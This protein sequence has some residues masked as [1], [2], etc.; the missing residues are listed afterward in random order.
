MK[1]TEKLNISLSQEE[2]ELIDGWRFE[3]RLPSRAAA[4]RELIGRS[5]HTRVADTDRIPDTK[6]I[7][8]GESP[9]M[10]QGLISFTI[11]DAKLADAPLIYVSSE[12]EHL[13][14]YSPSECIG[15]NCRFLQGPKT[16]KNAISKI[17]EAVENARACE[18]EMINYRKTGEP[19]EMRLK[20]DPLNVCGEEPGRFIV[21]TQI[22]LRDLSQG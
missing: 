18:V 12:F 22:F 11:A 19:F 7:G 1:R 13:S 17:R 14:G 6:E 16:R 4:V 15:R 9:F 5:I 21:G 3:N 2:V 20:L 10:R 8:V